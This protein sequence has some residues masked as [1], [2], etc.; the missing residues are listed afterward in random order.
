MPDDTLK[1][2]AWMANPTGGAQPISRPKCLPLIQSFRFFEHPY[3]PT[4]SCSPPYAPTNPCSPS[5]VSPPLISQVQPAGTASTQCPRAILLTQVSGFLNTQAALINMHSPMFRRHPETSAANGLNLS[6]KEW[7][8]QWQTG[9]PKFEFFKTIS[10]QG[11]CPT[12]PDCP[13]S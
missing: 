2:W 5:P 10:Q 13:Q 12:C 3:A 6:P 7:K 4:N 8:D 1:I 11:R 9:T